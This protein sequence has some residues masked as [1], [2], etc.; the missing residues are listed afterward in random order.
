MVDSPDE[1][2]PDPDELLARVEAEEA[3]EHRGR[4]KIFFGA[5]PGVGK[6][7]AM[8]TA[9]QQAREQGTDVVVGLVETHGR[10]ETERMTEGLDHLPRR[11]IEHRGRRLTE[12]DLDAALARRPA[13]LLVD[14]LAHTNAP[15]SRHPKRWQ[16]VQELLAAGI[17]VWTTVNVQHLES[18][19][20]IVGGI[21]GVRVHETL[22]DL[23]FDSAD[24][25]V[26][27]DLPPDE[28]LVRLKEGKVYV[29]EQAERAAKNFFRKGNL[30]ALRELALRRTADR[31]DREMR[32]YRRDYVGGNVWR[33]QPAILV[34]VG[35]NPGEDTVVRN[36]ARLAGALDARWHAIYVET[37]S[38]ARLSDERRAE[39][40]RVLR[41]A[42]TLGAQTATVSSPNVAA[43]LVAYA[44]EH[45]LASVVLGRPTIP[46]R[47]RVPWRRNAA[48]E[49]AQRA[50]DV[51]VV[52]V[53]RDARPREVAA[54]ETGDR[55]K[56]DLQGYA[57][58]AG[59]SAITTLV[60]TL[61][62]PYFDLANIAMVFLLAVV[63]AAMIAGRGPAIFAAIVNVLA[64]D[65]FFVP[66]R[67]SFAVSDV[68]YVVTFIV[69]LIVGLV[70]GQ[71]TASLRYQVR[72]ARLRESRAQR[73]TELARELSAA[74][75]E[76]QVAEISDRTI[77]MALNAKATVLLADL[78]DVLRPAAG[79]GERPTMDPAIARWA[80]DHNAPAGL[81]T[82]TLPAARDLYLPLK[83]PMR[84]RGVLAVE[85]NDPQAFQIP[86][87][88]QLLDT[89][90]ALVAIALERVH[91]V[92]VAQST[93]VQMESE[94]L[95]NSLLAALSHDLRT[96]LTALVGLADTLS[97]DI[98]QNRGT[99]A[100]TAASIR[101]QARRTALLV[102]NLLEM[103]RLQAGGVTLR[104]DW[105]SLEELAG[106]A[107]A[108]VETALAGHPLDLTIPPD[109]PLLHC[110][111]VL[112]ERVLVN[113][114]ENAA[115][116]TPAGTRIGLTATA[117]EEM[118]EITVWDEGPGLPA[119]DTAAL[120]DKFTRGD[121][122]SRVPGVGL[123][124]AICRA[125]VEAHGGTI[126][127][128][129]RSGGGARITFTLPRAT[130]PQ[131]EAETATS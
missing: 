98:A 4:L 32:S 40:V 91:F 81:G 129:N 72:V 38:L 112:I 21:T 41:L 35:P 128:F 13:V 20:D 86:E 22:P 122:E 26:L 64:F 27:V 125:I 123:G 51:D 85:P 44:R 70:I 69:M 54:S 31:V 16:D 60:A 53:A 7:F 57:V 111:G 33:A 102:D 18:L 95:R 99:P 127:A 92:T 87:Q 15:D 49:I 113:L 116:Y 66:P 9:A 52:Q 46:S 25:I 30:L 50:P 1:R 34:A 121:K 37:P 23:V 36:A 117:G 120:F 100:E 45:N 19:N 80:F 17:D 130:A 55:A 29:P 83:A 119:G 56:L 71:L 77:E 65:F 5:S 62:L 8:L 2:R 10:A 75:T 93:L 14:E 94:R 39:V 108:S 24:E 11:E 109:L 28:L 103:A 68:Q 96:P 63:A 43:A 76:E 61:L 74:L 73:L 97:M 58:A 110:D 126:A 3:R 88:R 78:D 124:L 79:S 42:A 67:F 101:D 118:I 115:K 90:A 59:M 6:T 82:D 114:L 12:F 47:W 105:Q 131:V 107:V 106:S 48:T 104:R 84:V 89:L